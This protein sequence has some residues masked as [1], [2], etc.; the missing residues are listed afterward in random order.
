MCAVVVILAIVVAL[1]GLFVQRCCHRLWH[2]HWNR[3]HGATPLAPQVDAPW[4]P[5]IVQYALT[6]DGIRA[7]GDLGPL[8]DY[9]NQCRERWATDSTLPDSIGELRACLFFE[10]RRFNHFGYE[11]QDDDDRYVRS[12]LAA[13]RHKSHGPTVAP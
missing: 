8:G 3:T 13:I 1:V 11:P 4:S 10:Q 12:L 5:D 7:F 2:R 9:A 6:F